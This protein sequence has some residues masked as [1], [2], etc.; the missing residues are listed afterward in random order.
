MTASR[1][2]K[3][4]SFF[5]FVIFVGHTIGTLFPI[6]FGLAGD[7]VLA[8]M[9]S[10]RFDM[11]GGERS[12]WHFYF[13]ANICLSLFLLL[14]ALLIWNLSKWTEKEPLAMKSVL[15]LFLSGNLALAI[16]SQI[17]FF[18][19]PALCALLATIC[20]GLALRSLPKSA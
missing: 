16:L 11:M 5:L 10:F 20:L 7:T 15:L 9:K 3:T 14:E 19:V 2:M 18:I 4:A 17:Y 6:S 1:W 8:G 12:Y 13:G